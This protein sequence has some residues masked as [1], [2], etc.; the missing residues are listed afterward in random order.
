MQIIGTI[1]MTIV[2]LNRS[3]LKSGDFSNHGSDNYR[4]RHPGEGRDPDWVTLLAVMDSG[5]H[6]ND[7]GA[8][9]VN[10]DSDRNFKYPI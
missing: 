10:R 7:G 5:M 9:L 6:R 3:N 8:C 1:V 4:F 2:T